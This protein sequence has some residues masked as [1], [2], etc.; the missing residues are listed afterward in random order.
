[1]VSLRAKTSDS[2]TPPQ[3][4]QRVVMMERIGFGQLQPA[5]ILADFVVELLSAGTTLTPDAFWAGL[6]EIVR[7]LE[8]RN[9]ALLEQ[10][11]RLRAPRPADAVAGIRSFLARHRVPGAGASF[12]AGAD[13][14]C[15]SRDR[16][17]G[18]PAARRSF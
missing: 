5:R 13:A 10:R 4:R 16:A 3:P 9:R 18:G 12:G 17:R 2:F 11:D 6:A 8:P 15:R 14:E 1:M 7:D